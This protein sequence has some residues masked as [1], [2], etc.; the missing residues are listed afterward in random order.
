[1]KK[2]HIGAVLACVLFLLSGCSSIGEKSQS[3]SLVYLIT[4]ILSLALF[5]G[6]III[7]KKREPWFVLLFFS[8]FVVNLGYL[9]IS[10]SRDLQTALYS[11]TLAYLGSVL[12]PLSMLFIIFKSC[13]IKVSSPIRILMFVITFLIFILAASPLLG[14][15]L[16]YSNVEWLECAGA[17]SLY[18]EYGSLHS[19]YFVYLI[20]YFSIMICSIIRSALKKKLDSPVY[21]VILSMAVFLNIGIWLLEQ[22]VRIDFEVLSVSY[23]ITELFL[24]ALDVMMLEAKNKNPVEGEEQAVIAK[25][26]EPLREG[27]DTEHFDY[28]ESQIPFLTPTE[29]KVFDLYVEGKKTKEVLEILNIKE[30]TLKYHNKNIYGKLGVSSRKELIEIAIAVNKKKT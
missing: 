3:L 30:N 9:C 12:L 22:L 28:Y 17:G 11:N 8:V 19:L 4:V 18:K 5:L 2:F 25:E 24:L 15:K 10:L 13:N 29:K 26:E 20:L 6:Y 16:Y 27:V 23:I 1:M 7:M 21:D 14:V